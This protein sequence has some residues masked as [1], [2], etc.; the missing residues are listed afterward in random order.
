LLSATDGIKYTAKLNQSSAI[1]DEPI[2]GLRHSQRVVNKGGRTFSVIN[3][4]QS[5]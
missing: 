3:L 1:A 2:D 5:N 4:R